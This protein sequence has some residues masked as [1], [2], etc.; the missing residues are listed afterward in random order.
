MA[1][2]I[3]DLTNKHEKYQFVAYIG[4]TFSEMQILV[5]YKSA[6]N[7]LIKDL[8]TTKTRVDVVTHPLLYMMRHSIELGYKNN[9]KYF[10]SY[11]GR[12]TS[13]RLFRSHDLQEL[14]IEFKTHFELAN[15]ALYFDNDLVI[16]FNSYYD[17]TTKLINQL[18]STEASSFRYIKNTKEQ[19]IFQ[20]AETKDIGEI[21]KLYDKAITMLIHTSDLV[22][23]YIDDIPTNL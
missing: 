16:E 22:S 11:N 2:E 3:I 1:S 17:E 10:E 23:S 21:K 5:E 19:R 13:K 8:R 15:S 14:H 9:F 20:A 4:H 7:I 12:Q 6:I 18:G